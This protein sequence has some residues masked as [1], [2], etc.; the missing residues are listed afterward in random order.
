M[1]DK[2]LCAAGEGHIYHNTTALIFP[3]FPRPADKQVCKM[4]AHAN[5]VVKLT[6]A[7]K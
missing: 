5:N 4:A 3:V 7:L 2:Q 1:N 6:E